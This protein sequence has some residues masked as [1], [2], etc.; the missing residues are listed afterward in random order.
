M[1]RERTIR[2][3]I[4]ITHDLSGKVNVKKSEKIARFDDEYFM[5]LRV[6]MKYA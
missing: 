6:E 1:F 2:D 3:E 5:D 4:K